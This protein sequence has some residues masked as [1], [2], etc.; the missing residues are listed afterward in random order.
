MI[1]VPP[2]I[3]RPKMISQYTTPEDYGD[4]VDGILDYSQYGKC[5]YRNKMTWNNDIK[6]NDIIL[7][8]CTLHGAELDKDLKF[9]ESIDEATKQQIITI[10]K[11]YWDCFVKEGAKRP[12]LSYEF[13][14]DTGGAKPV[15][16]RKPSYGPY[17]SKVIMEQISQLLS[18]NW[19]TKCEGPWGSMVV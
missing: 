2:K 15:C 16:C 3:W 18:N 14:I 1:E 13:G 17:E 10:V 19:I 6:R 11:K 7:Y 12:I 4:E 5:V 8:N 9:D